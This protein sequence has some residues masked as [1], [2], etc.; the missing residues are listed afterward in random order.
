MSALEKTTSIRRAFVVLGY[1]LV[2]WVLCAATMGLCMALLPTLEAMLV[3]VVAAPVLFGALSW[4][5]HR[6][7]AFTSPGVT[8]G[9]LHTRP[10]S[11]R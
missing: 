2:G 9:S 1:A 8:A 10:S 6:R 5:Y 3:H 4:S 7:Y 11:P